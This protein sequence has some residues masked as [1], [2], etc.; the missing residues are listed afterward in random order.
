MPILALSQNY[1][2]RRDVP[3]ADT[4]SQL[5]LMRSVA[6]LLKAALKG[7]VVTGISGS[8]SR[9]ANT[10]WAH[11]ASSDGSTTSTGADLWGS[12]YTAGALNWA[13]D[14]S[15]HS[16]IHLRNALLGRDL[17]I[18]LT[19]A[20]NTN[21]VVAMIPTAL[22]F[23]G[24]ST[25]NRPA[26]LTF[27]VNGG[28]TT[29]GLGNWFTWQANTTPGGTNYVHYT[30]GDDGSFWFTATRVGG[31]CGN[32]FFA[33]QKPQNVATWPANVSDTNNVQLI[34]TSGNM[35][36]P[37]PFSTGSLMS[38]TGNCITLLP[39]NTR[40]SA[41]GALTSYT[42]GG[43]TFGNSTMP[44]DPYTLE[45]PVLPVPILQ[46]NAGQS[47]VR[48]ILRDIWLHPNRTAIP[49]AQT[50]DPGAVINH[51]VFGDFFMPWDGA[52]GPTF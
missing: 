31:G 13:N 51:I 52:A 39:N 23:A 8:N 49:N 29:T 2:T 47:A 10:E 40:P 17:V 11:V 44:I 22:G 46:W 5:T 26:N 33:I 42:I 35:T 3:F 7:E 21:F 18:D 25:L 15:A 4:T 1:H 36:A 12:T 14:G 16:W 24:G 38:G 20:T 27:E 30:V 45:F 32:C 37:G 41:G 19:N 28:Y 9:Q 34:V 50:N 48:G 43:S 6:W